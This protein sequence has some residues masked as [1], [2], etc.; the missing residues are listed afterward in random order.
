MLMKGSKTP[1]EYWQSIGA[2]WTELARVS[3]KLFT[4]ATS[5]AASE[6]NF[7]TM[8]FIHGKLRNRMSPST[9]EK[10]VYIKCNNASFGK[11]T[12]G[13]ANKTSDGESDEDLELE[14][15]D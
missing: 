8:G 4:I 5:S 13:E 3:V 7:S 10:L 1:L 11:V 9:V 14:P 2:A 15:E 6:R 12:S